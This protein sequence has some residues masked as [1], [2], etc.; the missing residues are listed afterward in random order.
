MRMNHAHTPSLSNEK[1]LNNSS[2]GVQNGEKNIGRA[3]TH[4]PIA[5]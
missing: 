1:A 3:I 2:F 5:S 4:T